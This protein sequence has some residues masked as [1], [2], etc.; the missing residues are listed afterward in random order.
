MKQQYFKTLTWLRAVAAFFVVVSHS[1]RTSEVQYGA[2]DEASYFF[3]LSLLDLGTFGVYLFFALSGCTL[4]I[5]SHE[6]INS[7]GDFAP[8]YMKRFMRI[9]PAFAISLV[10]YLLF[11]EVFRHFYQLDHKFWI[12]QFLREYSF[13]N[14]LQ[15]LSLTFNITGPKGLFIG[16]Y[17]SLPIEFQYYLL[18]PFAILLMNIKKLDFI[19][20]VFFG[21]LLYFFHKYEIFQVESTRIF[22]MAFVFFGGV[23]LGKIH[24]TISFKFSFKESIF[25]FSLFVLFVGLIRTSIVSIPE[26]IPFISQKNNL[27]GIMA[28]LSVG[29]SLLT[30]AP[31]KQNKIFDFI[32][33]Y[34]TIS[35]SIYLFHMLFVGIAALLVINL[36]IYGDS[37][38]L[39][40]VLSFSLIGS[41]IFS[42]YSYRYLEEPFIKIGRN[43]ANIRKV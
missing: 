27:Y 3:P 4:F 25:I 43:F 16:P 26:Y 9:W 6:K 42:K 17:W 37:P 41:Y 12:A 5:S 13:T 21:G 35:Y 15:Y 1:I 20:P 11:I 28:I 30:N 40:F 33:E 8:F 10:I 24:Q 2:N 23:L 19:T 36:E 14:I 38:K 31:K 39:F 29:L 32:Q 22:S 7:I 34:G 18:L